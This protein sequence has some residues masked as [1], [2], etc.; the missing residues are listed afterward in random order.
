MKKNLLRI[1]FLLLGTTAF[2]QVIPLPQNPEPGKC[3]VMCK[4]PEVWKNEEVTIEIAPAFRKIVTHPAEYRTVTEKV[5]IKEAS[6]K[7]EIVPAVWK[8]RAIEYEAKENAS[9]LR[10]VNATFRQDS[11]TIETKASSAS[12]QMSG[13]KPG[14][15]SSDPND[16][17]YWCYK[18]IPASY[19]SI[20]LTK[21]VS[22]ASTQKKNVSGYQKSY[23]R[24]VI[25]SPESTRKIDIPAVYGTVNKTVLVKDAW[26]E[27][28]T[29]DAKYKTINKEVLVSKGGLTTWKEVECELVDNTPLPI[30]WKL[31]SATLTSDAKRIIDTR[32][33]PILKTG[34]AVAIESHT[35]SRGK[36][37]SNKDLSNRRAKAV[38]SYLISK[39][40]NSSQLVGSGFGETRLINRCKD[41]VVC[42]EAEHRQNRRT[43][44]R[45]INQQ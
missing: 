12:W 24:R 42:S 10:V 4:T 20:P 14:C 37:V 28:V 2:S 7:L 19:V 44:F 16:C 18:P 34:V 29:V 11:Q 13:K 15:E 22:D 31:N 8:T 32:L 3:Y 39:G 21:L 36:N 43:T 17:R 26:Q 9:E 6:T 5:L 41:G 40:I 27:E 45:V 35:D 33:L 1:T 25:V 30:N 38:T 23:T